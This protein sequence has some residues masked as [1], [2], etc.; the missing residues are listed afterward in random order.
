LNH[1]IGA[2]GQATV[3]GAAVI[4]DLVAVVT[5]LA[6]MQNPIAASGSLASVGAC[7]SVYVIAVVAR[8]AD[9]Y[10]TIPAIG[11]R[12]VGVTVA[13]GRD[14]TDTR[15]DSKRSFKSS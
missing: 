11:L 1:T 4:G 6:G 5:S 7:V 8:F 12:A 3:V 2:A 10:R 9:L 14:Q 15:Y 13:A